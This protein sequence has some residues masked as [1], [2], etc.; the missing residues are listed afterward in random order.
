MARW[1]AGT[2]RLVGLS[3]GFTSFQVASVE[4]TG[5]QFPDEA[6]CDCSSGSGRVPNNCVS[7]G[8]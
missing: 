7:S 3:Y 2:G 8:N 6:E 5:A 1:I 4:R